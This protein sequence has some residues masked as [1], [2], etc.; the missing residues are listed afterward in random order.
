MIFSDCSFS[1]SKTDS[2]IINE[3]HKESINDTIVDLINKED[4]VKKLFI[5]NEDYNA[6]KF[7]FPVGKPNAKGYY[8]AQ[9]FGKNNHLG[10][11]WNAVT[12]G[13]SDLG[14]PIYSVANGYVNFAEDIKGGW[15]NVIRI[16]HLT[17]E[18]KIVE[19]LYAHC[20]QIII[21]KG[22]F[23]KKGQKIATIGN[24]DGQYLAHLH[25]EMRDDIDLPVGQGYSFNKDGYI[26]PTKFI[27]ENQK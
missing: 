23:V 14:H 15:G 16:W 21:N 5:N 18:G 12:G 24:A 22:D 10:D 20:D 3:D 26:D 27:K 7:D 4:R 1:Q 2:I 8:N 13:N 9:S 11:D 25:L 19:S 6:L 17:T